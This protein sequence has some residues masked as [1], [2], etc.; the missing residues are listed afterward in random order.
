MRRYWTAICHRGREGH[1]HG[2]VLALCAA[3]SSA[4]VADAG[5]EAQESGRAESALVRPLPPPRWMVGDHAR[6]W[7]P[8]ARMSSLAAVA[9]GA[10]EVAA[11]WVATDGSVH[12]SRTA[13]G[14]TVE[15]A[16]MPANS[17]LPWG[18]LA[19]VEIG[20]HTEIAWV[21][22]GGSI[23]NTRW[24]H[25]TRVTEPFHIAPRGS[26][27][28][29]THVAAVRRTPSALDVFWVGADRSVQNGYLCSVETRWCA[30]EVAGPGSTSSFG[31]VAAVTAAPN[32]MTVFWVDGAGAVQAA[33]LSPGGCGKLGPCT[34]QYSE[35]SPAGTASLRGALSAVSPSPRAIALSWT[36]RDGAV[37]HARGD[38]VVWTTEPIAGPGS[39]AAS[40]RIASVVREPGALEVFWIAPDGS[41]QAARRTAGWS[42]YQLAD[43]GSA[44]VAS[45]LASVS[46]ARDLIDVWWIRYER[47]GTSDRRAT[48]LA[49][50]HWFEGP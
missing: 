25:G 43:P 5:D 6:T 38:G 39:A 19:A 37:R 31:R 30:V 41:I 17:A 8:V 12:E 47:T 14:T 44:P 11:F 36:G 33:H 35:V 10:T 18:G 34:W 24:H 22:P 9:R 28:T 48:W 13:G 45:G 23:E 26:A 29:T 15:L 16:I 20:P 2:W 46:A 32:E 7:P 21:G 42:V 49:N 40:G 3:L 27:A 4:C 50:A 1:S